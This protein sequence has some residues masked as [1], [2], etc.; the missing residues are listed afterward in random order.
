MR[1]IC[2]LGMTCLLAACGTLAM[3]GATDNAWPEPWTL[4]FGGDC[5]G[6]ESER[7]L[8]TRLD[9]ERM[10]FGD[11][12]LSRRES[13]SYAGS[14][15]FSAAM[16]VDGRDIPYTIAYSLSEREGGFVGT[17]RITEDGGHALD[18]PVALS[19]LSQR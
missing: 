11:Y 6:R 5:S 8:I 2:T 3:P 19:P 17:Q 9:D 4:S 18:C 10:V 1:S 7:L 14:A 13:G 12:N 16:P 15:L